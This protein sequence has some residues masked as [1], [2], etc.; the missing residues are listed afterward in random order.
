MGIMEIKKVTKHWGYELWIADGVRTPYASKRILFKAGNRTS[1]QVHEHK[2]ETNYVLSGTGILHRSKEPLDIAKFLEQGMTVKQVE[3]YE[4]TFDIIELKEGV[5]FDVSPGYVHRV[6]A[7]TDLE[8]MET[9]TT[10]L[11]D[12]IRLQDDQ[13]RTHGRISYEHGQV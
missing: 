10:E 13:G 1:L 8:F 3:D 2:F 11:D 9:S 4:A 7:T 5:V 6:L 12:V